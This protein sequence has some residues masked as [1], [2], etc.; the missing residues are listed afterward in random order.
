MVESHP[1]S[2][3]GPMSGIYDELKRQSR[4]RGERD[5]CSVIT[6][7]VLCGV[8]YDEAHDALK[9]CGRSFGKCVDDDTLVRALYLLDYIA[10]RIPTRQVSWATSDDLRLYDEKT[11]SGLSGKLPTN[12]MYF[13]R[14]TSHF[15]PAKNGI[16][17]DWS[18][19]RKLRINH[20]YKLFK[21][22]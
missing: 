13:I 18:A 6:A 15:A 17:D 16:I 10:L 14:T 12:E 8:S 4:I 1:T 20:I 22:E 3:S 9:E 21:R 11:T 2:A 19:T 7:A 5:D